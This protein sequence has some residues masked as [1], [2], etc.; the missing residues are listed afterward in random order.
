M[1]E[2]IPA[3]APA[4]LL[5]VDDEPS[6]LS[7]LRRLFRPCG[8]RILTAE[9][10]AA[11]LELLGHED[12]DLIISDMRMPE[13]DGAQFLE[14]VRAEWPRVVRILLTGYADITSTVNA[15]NKGEIYRYISKP[16]DDN[17]IVLIVRD[18]LERQRLQRENTR[19][20]ALTQSQ[21]EELKV[22][23]SGLEARVRERTV[24]LEQVNGFLN[25][26]ND[27]L[28]QS[29]LVSIKVFS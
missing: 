2:Q 15:I 11:G 18:A 6:I 16:W 9:S 10:G 29:F 28:K 3:A 12:V 23:N 5:L 14:R 13:M 8:Y 27:T 21:N 4:T 17:D 7:A 26:A 22:L 19:L 20:L 25:L 1:T 24:E